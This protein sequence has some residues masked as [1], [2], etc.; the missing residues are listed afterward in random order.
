M[1]MI[2]PGAQNVKRGLLDPCRR[3]AGVAVFPDVK[4]NGPALQFAR[5]YTHEDER[6]ELADAGDTAG[7]Q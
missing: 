3:Y 7:D 1:K 2:K 4:R 6:N 5:D